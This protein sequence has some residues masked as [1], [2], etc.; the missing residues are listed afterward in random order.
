MSTN[1]IYKRAIL[2]NFGMRTLRI[3]VL[4]DVEVSYETA[5]EKVEDFLQEFGLPAKA[6][7]ANGFALVCSKSIT[8]AMQR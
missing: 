5:Y 8:E 6:V 7:Q 1:H 4:S 2:F 3:N